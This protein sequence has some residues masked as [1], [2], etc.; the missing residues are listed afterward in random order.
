[1]KAGWRSMAAMGAAL[2]GFALAI[3]ATRAFAAG[4]VTAHK[5][6]PRPFL[7]NGY[8]NSATCVNTLQLNHCKNSIQM[9]WPPLRNPG[10]AEWEKTHRNFCSITYDAEE[11]SEERK[12]SPERC[13]RLFPLMTAALQG[14]PEIP[15]QD[16]PC[17]HSGT[18]DGV[19]LISQRR[20]P[21][22]GPGA[23]DPEPVAIRL[24][25]AALCKLHNEKRRELRCPVLPQRTQTWLRKFL[26]ALDV[27]LVI[28]NELR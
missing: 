22:G 28:Q 24:A 3:C 14:F 18:S 16:T 1:M 26:A 8:H 15:W 25:D 19:L 2:T 5:A 13:E 10:T 17:T 23:K 4:A 21:T 6:L 7:C 12:F 27:R 11:A 20:E 9:R